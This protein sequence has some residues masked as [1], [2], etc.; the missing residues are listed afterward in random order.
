MRHIITFLVF[1]FPSILLSQTPY[2]GSTGQDQGIFMGSMG[3]SVIDDQTFFTMRMRPELAIGK[4]GFGLDIPIRFNLDSGEIR[5]ADWDE[6][7]DYLR[8]VRYARYGQKREPLYSRI[9]DLDATRIGHGFIMNFYNNNVVNYDQRKVGLILDVDAGMFGVESM[10]NN[11]GRAE[12]FG[13]RAYYRPLFGQSLFLLENLA[14]G[15]S[16]VTDIDPDQN[17]S[18]ADGLTEFGFDV[19]LPIVRTPL[20][21]TILYADFAKIN[22]YGSG[23][24]AGVET[25]FRGL[26]GTFNITAQLERRFLGA[27]FLPAYFNAFYELDRYRPGSGTSKEATL[28]VQPE[29]QGTFGLLHGEILNAFQLTGTFEKLDDVKNSGLLHMELAVPNTVPSISARGTYDRVG[30]DG[31]SDAFKLDERSVAKFGLGYKINPFIMVFMDY[32]WTFRF[33]PAGNKYV[34]QKHI[35]PQISFVMPFQLAR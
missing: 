23:Q 2:V 19:E 25:T 3:V 32:V 1:L 18:T 11:V 17:R 34:S 5:K 31:F 14:F 12:I 13:G 4:F 24:A 15:A 22:G 30:I 26:L 6:S 28:S 16:I 27:N 35:E 33:D 7:Y 21:N 29:A 8:V 10:T 9:G 20:V